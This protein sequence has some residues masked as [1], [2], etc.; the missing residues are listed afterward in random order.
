MQLAIWYTTQIGDTPFPAS[1]TKY[2]C[3]EITSPLISCSVERWKIYVFTILV[4]SSFSLY[5]TAQNSISLCLSSLCRCSIFSWILTQTS[6]LNHNN[7]VLYFGHGG[8]HGLN[9]AIYYGLPIVS[10]PV[11]ADG[12]ESVQKL[13]KKGVAV[14]VDKW[15]SADD[16]YK[17]IVT[18]R[19]DHR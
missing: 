9:E 12:E 19:D 13:V 7:T 16:M 10:I 5:C 6:I 18:V 17:A 14:R 8:L 1:P 3:L 2:M 11:W 4:K 15:A